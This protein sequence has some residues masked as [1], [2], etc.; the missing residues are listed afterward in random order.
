[1]TLDIPPLWQFMILLA[2]HYVADFKLQTHW[3]ATNKSK[4]I[5][6]LLEHV[7]VYTAVLAVVAVVLFGMTGIWFAFVWINGVLHFCTDFV[8]SR[9]SA[10]PFR[11]AIRDHCRIGNFVQTYEKEPNETD[12][13]RLGIRVG[14]HWHSFFGVMGFDQLIH[15]IALG[16]TLSLI[17]A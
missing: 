4:N 7:A 11:E 3:Q 2:A 16:V 1:M 15:Q 8:T 12:M 6:A 5:M 9:W 14:E 17:V 13:R 10:V